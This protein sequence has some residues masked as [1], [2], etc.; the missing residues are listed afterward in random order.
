MIIIKKSN[1]LYLLLLIASSS[2]STTFGKRNIYV[3]RFLSNEHQEIVDAKM[4]LGATLLVGAGYFAGR[5]TS[6]SLYKF[7]QA[8]YA[9][10][11]DLLGRAAYNEHVI[12]EELI[13]YI[14]EQHDLSNSFHLI[15]NPYRGYPL[16]KYKSDLDWYINHL[17]VF[18]FFYLGTKKSGD[19]TRLIEK[20]QRVRRY[21]VTDYRFVLEERQFVRENR[22]K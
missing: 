15:S 22:K 2:F 6:W 3:D 13:P 7:A 19:I 4:I 18:K 12:Q 17:W 9:P 14:L 20:L 21:I 16:L 11:F 1:C 8:R 10:E 5:M